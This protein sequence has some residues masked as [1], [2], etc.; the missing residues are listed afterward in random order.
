MKT[1]LH[2]DRTHARTDDPPGPNLPKSRTP[3][4]LSTAEVVVR[5]AMMG[6]A[7]IG[8]LFGVL[9]EQA[10]AQPV[11]PSD[12][13]SAYTTH[14][15]ARSLAL[16]GGDSLVLVDRDGVVSLESAHD[17]DAAIQIVPPGRE[18]GVYLLP[19]GRLSLDPEVSPDRPIDQLSA[20]ALAA[21][22]DHR[23]ENNLFGGIS[24]AHRTAVLGSLEET[25]AQVPGGGQP[26]DGLDEAQ[27]LQVRT[28]TA[29][30]LLELADATTSPETR[31]RIAALYDGLVRNEPRADVRQA[32]ALQLSLSPAATTPEVVGVANAL[33]PEFGAIAPDY[34]AWLAD[35]VIDMTW[36]AGGSE[37]KPGAIDQLEGIGFEIVS[38]E[39]GVTALEKEIEVDGHGPALLRVQVQVGSSK[40]FD[41]MGDTA[42]DIVFYDGHSNYGRNVER[43][44][45]GA[46]EAPDGGRG[47]LIFV[48]LCVGKYNL[49]SMFEQYPNAQIVTTF[50]P[51]IFRGN[52]MYEGENIDA[53][54]ALLSD[55][56]RRA[57]WATIHADMEAASHT[58][59]RTAG[60]LES[61]P[62]GWERPY[63]NYITPYATY[64]R[65]RA[66]DRDDD[67]VAD[68]VDEHYNVAPEQ[69]AVDTAR[70]LQ[71][72]RHD[73]IAFDG[74]AFQRAGQ[75][76]NRFA[77]YNEVIQ[78]VFR[79][80][81][82]VANGYFVPGPEDASVVR[83]R[84]AEGPEGQELYL[85]QLNADF[86]HMSEETLRAVVAF[87]LNRF[88][89]DT[90]RADLDPVDAK[91]NGLM[92][93]IGTMQA[94][95]SSRDREI[96]STLLDAYG[97]PAMDYGTFAGP[98]NG[99]HDHH[100]GG[101]ETLAEIRAGLSDEIIQALEREDTGTYR[102]SSGQGTRAPA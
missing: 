23:T 94:D 59:D 52:P 89:V 84:A 11:T 33:K 77:G 45:G 1:R 53:L 102:G 96:W 65:E 14:I 58:W 57:D 2:S 16:E 100:A 32:L 56:E 75:T 73:A 83:F 5:S 17:V 15:D 40:M 93:V 21:E 55:V 36:T 38:D 101:R 80:S 7:G 97:L 91:I 8:M 50:G 86:A 47:K 19:D 90:G 87:E 25:L 99:D 10:Q 49:D 71:P 76:A 82:L 62:F 51:S 60:R 54:F 74:A 61:A 98:V 31:G 27:A 41:A 44:L 92:M 20:L 42:T 37:F 6:A 3:Q 70:E 43:A 81:R 69:V 67:G 88:L 46:P 29:T 24:E 4:R 63:D 48:G 85:M 9:T 95:E 35:G 30:L 26:P 18:G 64:D 34:D 66:L 22:H 68:Y 13:G 12:D 28:S 72:I 39:R 79:D 78:D